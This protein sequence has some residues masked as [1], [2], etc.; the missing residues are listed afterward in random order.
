MIKQ[1][2]AHLYRCNRSWL[3]VWNKPITSLYLVTISLP[4]L[5]SLPYAPK[6]LALFSRTKKDADHWKSY[7]GEPQR[8]WLQWWVTQHNSSQLVDRGS[9]CWCPYL[10]DNLPGFY[11]ELDLRFPAVSL[12]LMWFE[13]VWRTSLNLMS[14]LAVRT[15]F[16]CK[17]S[18][19]STLISSWAI[20]FVHITITLWTYKASGVDWGP[21]S[22]WHITLHHPNL[23]SQSVS[24]T[25]QRAFCW[26][27]KMSTQFLKMK[28]ERRLNI[29]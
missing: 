17:W 28:T 7:T 4:Y 24:S 12:T 6:S 19:S 29:L 2:L 26:Y 8:Q 16:L 23:H 22:K 27:L 3:R 11:L 13:A 1:P 9:C 14:P 25:E 5:L 10:C 21:S 15:Y 18:R 20:W